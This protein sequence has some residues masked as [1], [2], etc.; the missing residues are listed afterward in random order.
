MGG[1]IPQPHR[2]ALPESIEGGS[3]NGQ[4]P[5][6][7]L[8]SS[9][10]LDLP[11]A[12]RVTPCFPGGMRPG[13]ERTPDAEG[14]GTNCFL[15]APLGRKLEP[16]TWIQRLRAPEGTGCLSPQTRVHTFPPL[17]PQRYFNQKTP[18]QGVGDSRSPAINSYTLQ[19]TKGD[20]EQTEFILHQSL[21]GW[22]IQVFGFVTQHNFC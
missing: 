13:T 8:H 17:R 18:G 21:S 14:G 16:C 4:D 11:F 5:C 19:M 12:L 20:L 22:K 3:G 10:P 1:V 9:F 6:L 7:H 15:S 2:Q